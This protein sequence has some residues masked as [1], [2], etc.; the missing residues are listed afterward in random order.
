MSVEYQAAGKRKIQC[1]MV[2]A[3][4]TPNILFEQLLEKDQ[5]P[6]PFKKRIE[7]WHSESAT[8]RMNV[9]LSELPDFIALPGKQLAEHHQSGI[10]IGP[11]LDYLD[12]AYK[13]AMHGGFSTKPFIEM[14]IPSTLDGSLAPAGQHVASL[15]CQH[16]PYDLASGKK[17]QDEKPKVI[18]TII[19][20]VNLYAPNFSDSIL[21]IQA[22]SAVDLEKKFGLTRGDIFHGAL[23]LNQLYHARPAIGYANYRTPVKNVY[24]CGSGAHPGGGVSGL[25]GRNCALRMLKDG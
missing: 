21:G 4:V 23:R 8:F 16:F 13:Q 19:E 12:D 10:V 25:P 3:N 6:A 15:F 17:W 9:A 11:S 5:L 18:E 22:L 14:L 24:L 20:T 7:Q 2:A 1:D